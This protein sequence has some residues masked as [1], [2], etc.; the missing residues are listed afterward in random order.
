MI[1]NINDND[2]LKKDLVY[3]IYLY[4]QNRVVVAT[5]IGLAENYLVYIKKV[6]NSSIDNKN[7]EFKKYSD[8]SR[9]KLKND[10][11]KTYE[12]YLRKKYKI[13]INYSALDNVKNYF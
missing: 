11:Y 12:T 2:I 13:D 4:P 8:L 9:S 1:K 5:D 10:L 6:N 7:K 3:Q